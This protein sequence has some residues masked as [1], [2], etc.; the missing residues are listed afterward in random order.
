[1]KKELSPMRERRFPLVESKA[2]VEKMDKDEAAAIPNAAT[3]PT[4]DSYHHYKTMTMAAS[5]PD[6]PHM[7]PSGYTQDHPFSAAY[8]DIEKMMIFKA[9]KLCGF[10]AKE[11]SD[12]YSSESESVNK[13]SPANHNS[14]INPK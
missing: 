7:A 13:R 2:S 10:P 11:I 3:Y 14:G 8:T 4:M 6:D 12:S 1:M 5:L 9:A